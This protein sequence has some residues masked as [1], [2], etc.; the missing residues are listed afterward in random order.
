MVTVPDVFPLVRAYLDKG[1]S[2]ALAPILDD[3]Q[4]L[5]KDIQHCKALAQSNDDIEA[6]RLADMFLQMS[7]L[8]RRKIH[9]SY[10]RL[11]K[12]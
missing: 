8:Q 2:G 1:G 5:D 12:V 10:Q 6:A 3:G 4:Y 9:R 7:L 11:G